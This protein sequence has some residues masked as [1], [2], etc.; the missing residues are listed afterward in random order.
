MS[1]QAYCDAT[2]EYADAFMKTNSLST[3]CLSSLPSQRY[4]ADRK[5]SNERLRSETTAMQGILEP[6]PITGAL[7]ATLFV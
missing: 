4:V 1:M 3:R 6:E 7:R 5:S 2:L